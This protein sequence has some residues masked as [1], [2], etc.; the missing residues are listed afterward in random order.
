MLRLKPDWYNRIT[1][2]NMAEELQN[3]EE[4]SDVSQENNKSDSIELRES[5]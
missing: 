5:D 1:W 2:S 4:A 3:E